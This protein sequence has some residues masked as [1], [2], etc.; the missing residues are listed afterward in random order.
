M[1]VYRWVDLSQAEFIDA[2]RP[3][4][5]R[6]ATSD[7]WFID[8]TYVKVPPVDEDLSVPRG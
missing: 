1:T 2:A 5:A 3:P 6:H 4:G 8:K 7:R